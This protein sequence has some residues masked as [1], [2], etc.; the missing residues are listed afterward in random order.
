[1]KLLP[2]NQPPRPAAVADTVSGKSAVQTGAAS[3]TELRF[4]DQT[5]TRLGANSYFSFVNGTRDMNLGSGTMLLQV[6]KGAGGAE[7]H[8][9]AVTA[10]ITGTTLMVEF[11]PKSY[12]KIIVLEGTVRVFLTR[13]IGESVLV[14]AGQ[15]VIVPPGAASMPE[16]VGVDLKVLYATS[17]LINDFGPLASRGLIDRE[18]T[19]Q[20]QDI[21]DGRLADTDLF[22]VAGARKCRRDT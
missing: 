5:L 6:P 4:S 16:P 22:I 12:S 14:H 7:I 2:E 11:N 3:R 8:T 10:A 21:H 9:A 15:M 1:M 19:R 18:V 20:R 17:G 13:R